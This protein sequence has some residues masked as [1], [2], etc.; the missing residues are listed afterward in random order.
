MKRFKFIGDI[1]GKP[2]WKNHVKDI[3]DYHEIIFLGDY[4]DAYDYNVVDIK[5]NFLKIIEWKQKFPTKI[6]LLLGNHD[7]A[8]IHGFSTISGYQPHYASVYKEIF[9]TNKDLFTMAWGYEDKN[10]N[11]YYLATHA[12][13]HNKWYIE[14][15]LNKFKNYNYI[16]DKNIEDYKL[17]EILNYL[18]D[19]KDIMWMVG[20]MRGGTNNPG[21][22]W[23][24]FRELMENPYPDINQIVGHT[25]FGLMVH[26]RENEILYGV[27]DANAGCLK[28]FI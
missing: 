24:D 15:I 16:L 3:Q 28:L 9:E 25:P 5:D 20:R 4:V 27:D 26:H 22:L 17:H 7:Y 23:A 2:F 8:Y 10:T 1:H 12:G 19:K 6:T 21:P 11:K 13:L 14:N 18:K